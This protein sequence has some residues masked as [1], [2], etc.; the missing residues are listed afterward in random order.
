M[1][2]MVWNKVREVIEH[3]KVILAELQR[4]ADAIKS[5]NGRVQR[6]IARIE[7]KINLN[8]KQQD[9]LLTLY[10]NSDV[11][12]VNILDIL[13]QLKKEKEELEAQVNKLNRSCDEKI[14]MEQARQKIEQYGS[15]VR[16]KLNNYT[17]HEKR[18][19]LDALDVQVVATREKM[20]IRIAVPL[21]LF[22]I[23]QTSACNF[24]HV[25]HIVPEFKVV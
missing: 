14:D 4:R 6:E 17:Y 18:Q 10:S 12:Q 13:G 16:N 22:T 5:G 21:E 11:D 15:R 23:E 19:A 1:E 9:R 8:S 25:K 2:E 24:A 3:P 20:K 7:R